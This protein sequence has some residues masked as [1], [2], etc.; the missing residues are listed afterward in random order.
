MLP[1]SGIM[2]SS[3]L[4]P[5]TQLTKGA[6]SKL[7]MDFPLPA[8]AKPVSMGSLKMLNWSGSIHTGKNPS[9]VSA[10]AATPV[11]VMVAA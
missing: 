1:R 8:R 10:A 9:Q 11:G 3:T 6:T 5:S 7:S 4:S 2:H